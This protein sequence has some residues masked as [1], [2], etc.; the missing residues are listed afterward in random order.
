MNKNAIN[1]VLLR[2][3]GHHKEWKIT[4]DRINILIDST[5]EYIIFDAYDEIQI[6]WKYARIDVWVYPNEK[7]YKSMIN[8]FT[9]Y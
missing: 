8:V 5:D 3:R 1:F 9:K 4:K 7:E 2:F 6:I